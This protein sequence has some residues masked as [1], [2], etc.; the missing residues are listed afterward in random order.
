MVFQLHISLCIRRIFTDI[1]LLCQV[2]RIQDKLREAY[3]RIY[4]IHGLGTGEIRYQ[5]KGTEMARRNAI[6][7]GLLF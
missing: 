3:H 6:V 4:Q 1:R 2:H 7:R 5:S